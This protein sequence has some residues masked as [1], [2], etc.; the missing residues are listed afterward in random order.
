M[1]G[2]EHQLLFQAFTQRLY[3][4]FKQHR[5]IFRLQIHGSETT[6]LLNR[7]AEVLP[8]ATVHLDKLQGFGIEN[9]Y[10]V[11][12]AFE[13]AVEAQSP[14]LY[15]FAQAYVSDDAGGPPTAA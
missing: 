10:L 3:G 15:M 7:V 14:V 12:G 13:D 11:Q 2:G 1:Y 8:G 9:I 4:P 6:K 5:R